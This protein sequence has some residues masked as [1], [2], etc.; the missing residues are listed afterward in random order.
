[1][2]R[3]GVERGWSR[4]PIVIWCIQPNGVLTLSSIQSEFAVESAF[5]FAGAPTKILT[6]AAPEAS[7]QDPKDAP[8]A[9]RSDRGVSARAREGEREREGEG[10]REIT[11]GAIRG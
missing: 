9:A 11:Y 8:D 7:K 5:T 6:F 4:A 3:R 2:T 10:E 1:V